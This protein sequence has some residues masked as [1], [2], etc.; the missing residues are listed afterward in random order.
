MKRLNINWF[1]P[2]PPAPTGISSHYTVP[3][4][5]PL[6]RECRL[7]LWSD[8]ASVDPGI[9]RIAPVRR[10]SAGDLSPRDFG[11]DTIN[12]YQVGNNQMHANIYAVARR[13]PGIVIV[14]D[15]NLFDLFY[16][17]CCSRFIMPAEF[18][19]ALQI[20]HGA[21]GR[22]AGE[23]FFGSASLAELG[24]WFPMTRAALTAAFAVV[25]HSREMYVMLAASDRWAVRYLPLAYPEHEVKLRPR[26]DLVA[27]LRL[28]A[29]GYFGTNRR[30]EELLR[31]IAAFPAR[32]RVR[33]DIYG[34]DLTGSIIS[35]AI[36]R[37]GLGGQVRM[38]GY[39]DDDVLD[40]ALDEADLAINLRFPTKGE[41]SGSQLRIWQHALPSINTPVG[42]YAEQPAGSM[43][44]VRPQH[45][46]AD[47]QEHFA[48]FL[49][50]PAPFA[51][52]GEAG[53]KVYIENHRPEA[54]AKNLLHFCTQAAP[55][56]KYATIKRL[57]QDVLPQI[58]RLS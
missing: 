52:I 10:Y 14:H 45:E 36:G 13:F 50:D 20:A 33:L 48:A 44:Y 38:H 51:R 35:E 3:L 40:A 24:Q 23:L 39:V 22:R 53:R 25:V 37:L 7:T 58:P 6:A 16:Y 12:V 46:V 56:R 41:A 2:L 17:M 55:Y 19:E 9:E 32:D 42:W 54:Y 49:K 47:L 28:V 26:K 57:I 5:P 18:R 31:A 29:F 4:L 34:Q 11:P 1:S 27:C 43:A 21:I 8:Q 30:I 15:P